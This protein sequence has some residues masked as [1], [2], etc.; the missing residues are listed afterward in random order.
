MS[1]RH[2][3]LLAIAAFSAA[4][5]LLFLFNLLLYLPP[6][7]KTFSGSVS[8][9]I[10]V[11]DEELNIRAC[12]ES[13]LASQQINFEILI[14]DDGS[15]DKTSA[16]V[17]EIA[18]KDMRVRLLRGAELPS[19][20]N[21]KQYA[22]W[23][24]ANEAKYEIFLFLD[25]DVRVRPD[26]LTLCAAELRARNVKLLSGF[27]RQI[28]VGFLEKLLL[29][30][31][32][33][34]LL[35][36]LPFVGM[37][38]TTRPA[39]AAGCGQFLL[40]VREAYFS[41]GG[42]AAIRHTRHD[43]LLLPQLFRKHGLR[44]DLVDLTSLAEVRMYRT[45][46]EVWQ[47]LAKNATEGMASPG[48]IVPFTLLL[49]VGQVMPVVLVLLW[50]AERALHLTS[51]HDLLLAHS[52]SPDVFLMVAVMASYVPRLA[53][54]SRFRQP[55]SSAILHPFGVSVLVVLQWYAFV[56]LVLRR[57]VSWRARTYPTGN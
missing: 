15:V 5:A 30:L 12:L 18:A 8:V 21:G 43:G 50:A 7:E 23:Q 17:E 1:L 29:P 49:V 39:F 53:A 11:R 33:F 28:T 47:G 42:H 54:V 16:I 51:K 48:R 37:R 38:R 2:G 31:I 34:V 13:V 40:V 36:Y 57:P 55:L 6:R 35:A 44:T 25:A 14:L 26:A 22:C 45:A 20:W 24:L 27:P 52:A 46:E 41:A 9:L 4:P 19:G 3:W 56:R 10:P 32:H